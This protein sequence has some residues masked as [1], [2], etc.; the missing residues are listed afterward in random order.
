MVRNFFTSLPPQNE[1]VTPSGV[2]F[3]ASLHEDSLVL[4]IL[5]LAAFVVV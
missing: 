5:G 3:L 4:V 2:Q 1:R